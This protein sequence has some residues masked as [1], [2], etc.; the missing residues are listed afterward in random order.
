MIVLYLTIFLD[1]CIA[2]ILFWAL[3]SRVTK[4]VRTGYMTR[5]DLYNIIK[6]ISFS[7]VVYYPCLQEYAIYRNDIIVK[8]DAYIYGGLGYKIWC[9]F[10]T[11]FA[12]WHAEKF[13]K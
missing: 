12:V 5:D 4:M 10:F 6:N 9:L 1:A 2:A 3:G 13:K 8:Y 7:V 11:W